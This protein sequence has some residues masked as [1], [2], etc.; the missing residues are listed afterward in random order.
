MKM[1]KAAKIPARILEAL[2]DGHAMTTEQLC[3]ASGVHRTTVSGPA[4]ELQHKG[5]IAITQK[6]VSS[7][8]LMNVFQIA[9][10]SGDVF[11]HRTVTDYA[12]TQAPKQSWF[13]A[14][15]AA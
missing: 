5:L 4:R 8:N 9:G 15:V 14:L 3:A 2:K 6:Y 1:A 11:N 12:K 10:G 13:S 7:G